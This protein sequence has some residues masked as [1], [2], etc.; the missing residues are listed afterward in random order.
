MKPVFSA[1]FPVMSYCFRHAHEAGLFTAPGVSSRKDQAD[2]S[3]TGKEEVEAAE[4][5]A[6]SMKL[7]RRQQKNH[8]IVKNYQVQKKSKCKKGCTKRHSPWTPCLTIPVIEG[9]IPSIIYPYFTPRFLDAEDR[10]DS[11]S[12]QGSKV[13]LR[14]KEAVAR[15]ESEYRQ[16]TSIRL[17]MA[18]E[19]QDGLEEVD[20][21]E[22]ELEERG[23]Q[24]EETIKNH[25]PG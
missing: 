23:K 14:K 24:V 7:R 6:L 17:L 12:I 3:S 11:S 9:I 5:K 4:E 22:K 1:I 19:I 10:L 18:Q 16:S 2:P 8:L 25:R 13:Y 20:N 15:P 21:E